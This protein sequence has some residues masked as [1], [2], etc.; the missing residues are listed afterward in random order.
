M[1]GSICYRLLSA[2]ASSGKENVTSDKLRSN[3][4]QLSRRSVASTNVTTNKTSSIHQR[5]SFNLG[6]PLVKSQTIAAH[7]GKK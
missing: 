6:K 3:S 4:L 1:T 7:G 5:R 2:M